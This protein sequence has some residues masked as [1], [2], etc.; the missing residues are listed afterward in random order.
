MVRFF[1]TALLISISIASLSAQLN[2]SKVK[3]NLTQTPITEVAA[4][5]LETDHGAYAPGRHL[6]NDFSESEIQ[7]LIDHNIPH[8]ILIEDVIAWYQER[9]IEGLPANTRDE[10][11]GG[12][13]VPLPGEQYTTPANYQLGSMGGYHTYTEM[14]DVLDQMSNLYPNLITCL[15]YTSPSPRD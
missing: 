9:N 8:E 12:A 5:G 4:L 2:Y 3:I 14:L 15:L 10:S 13:S 7:Q 11:C 6:I 1:L